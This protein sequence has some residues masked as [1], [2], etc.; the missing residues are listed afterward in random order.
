MTNYA[1]MHRLAI[2]PWERYGQAAAP[3]IAALLDREETRRSRP[4]GRALDLGCLQGFDAEQRHAEGV[5]CF[6][7]SQP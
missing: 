4:P 2:T 7:A 6:C 1:R 3:S 5:G